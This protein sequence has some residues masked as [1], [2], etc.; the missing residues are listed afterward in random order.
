MCA[1]AEAYKFFQQ[2]TGRVIIFNEEINELQP[3]YFPFSPH[4]NCS[5][6]AIEEALNNKINRFSDETK[7][8]SFMSLA[9]EYNQRLH[10]E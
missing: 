1:F 9:E 6:P 4:C 5:S 8:T 2:N 10:V 3:I 7:I